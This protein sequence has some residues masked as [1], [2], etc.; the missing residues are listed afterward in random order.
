MAGSIEKEINEM[1]KKLNLI[2][3][4]NEKILDRLNRISMALPQSENTEYSKAIVEF[5]NDFLN[6]YP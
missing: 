3:S 4:Q 1:N 6:N 2:I 5:L